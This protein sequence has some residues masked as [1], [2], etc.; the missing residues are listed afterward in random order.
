MADE[1]H[2]YSTFKQSD[3]GLPLESPLKR[4]FQKIQSFFSKN[5]E[6]HSS[7]QGRIHEVENECEALVESLTTLKESSSKSLD[8]THSLQFNLVIDGV[9]KE[10]QRIRRES[11][12]T[13]DMAH[14]V[15]SG[16]RFKEWIEQARELLAMK[17]EFVHPKKV[18]QYV[19]SYHIIE[20]Q[21]RIDRDLQLIEDYLN[22]AILENRDADEE[23]ENDQE[24]SREEVL[25]AI[26][27]VLEKLHRLKNP[28]AITT[29]EH[30]NIWKVA[31]DHT[32]G[33]N[34]SEALHVIDCV[35]HRTE[36]GHV[37]AAFLGEEHAIDKRIGVLE[38]HVEQLK[39]A[40][41]TMEAD[42]DEE[43]NPY[44]SLANQLEM[45]AREINRNPEIAPKEKE[46]IQKIISSLNI[47]RKQS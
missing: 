30:L 11:G 23:E 17:K 29:I 33:E 1:I 42:F 5:T 20:F 16:Q 21:K 2:K 28:E 34:F 15:K 24:V 43:D 45:E 8:A 12:R 47:F 3:G 4:Y 19:V 46:K 25:E 31:A 40:C 6:V 27:P 44:T 26:E 7:L 10:L 41:D 13:N 37:S 35:F 9:I 18:F 38:E 14:H 39:E 32:R 36:F 22:H